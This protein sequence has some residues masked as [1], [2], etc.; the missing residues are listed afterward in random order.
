MSSVS[1]TAKSHAMEKRIVVFGTSLSLNV[2][3]AE[4]L[5]EELRGCVE[6]GVSTATVAAAGRGSR[7]GISVLDRVENHSPSLVLIEFSINDADI[8]DGVG[9]AES[10]DNHRAII[11]HLRRSLEPAPEIVLMTMNPTD[12]SPGWVRPYLTDYYA[13]YHALAREMKTH[14]IDLH[15]EW[16]RAI[17]ETTNTDFISDGLHPSKTEFRQVALPIIRKKLIELLVDGT[18]NCLSMPE[19]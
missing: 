7:W 19:P 3:L 2:D 5:E 10:A 17:R 4:I 11:T 1:V 9:L 8:F 13:A 15:P 14:L 16:K 18:S 6:D 12:G